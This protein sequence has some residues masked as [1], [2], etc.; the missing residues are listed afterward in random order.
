MSYARLRRMRTARPTNAM[1][2]KP[3]RPTST[4]YGQPTQGSPVCEGGTV[5]GGTTG[6]VVVV[7]GDVVVVVGDVVVVVGDVVVVV[8]DVVVVVGDVVV[9]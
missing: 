5:V 9:V 1:P 7:V 3:A 6:D 2:K 8:G 4:Q